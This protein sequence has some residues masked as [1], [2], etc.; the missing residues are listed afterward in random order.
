[1]AKIFGIDVAK[2]VDKSIQGAGGVLT[3][4]LVKYEAGARTAGSLT[5]GTNPSSSTHSFRGFLETKGER[6]P[7]GT[8]PSS[9]AVVSVLGASVNPAAVPEVN[10]VVTIEGKTLTLLELLDR[11]PAS[12]L[13]RFRAQEV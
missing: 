9:N 13:Y 2:L 8:A 4:S 1:M 11:D 5:G 12:A 6:R 3:G 7:G 10:D